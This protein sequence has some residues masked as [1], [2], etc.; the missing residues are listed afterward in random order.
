MCEF[1][2]SDPC[3]PDSVN[4]VSSRENQYVAFQEYGVY[5]DVAFYKK[6]S[7]LFFRG[8]SARTEENMI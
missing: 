3:G 6:W 1:R 5:F 8:M 4:S 7:M 2:D